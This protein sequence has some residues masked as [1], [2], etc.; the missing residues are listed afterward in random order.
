M[1]LQ[2]SKLHSSTL[3]KE[4]ERLLAEFEIIEAG[5][6]ADTR[7]HD[8]DAT[9]VVLQEHT[10]VSGPERERCTEHQHEIE[11][12]E[13]ENLRKNMQCERRR[14]EDEISARDEK[15]NGYNIE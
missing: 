12:L 11:R 15:V 10:E 3:A 6:N 8:L 4:N 7:S 14:W 1:Q 13:W 9:E 5:R 2:E